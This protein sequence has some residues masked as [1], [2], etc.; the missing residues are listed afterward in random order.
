MRSELNALKKAVQDGEGFYEGVQREY[1]QIGAEYTERSSV[2]P[3]TGN[4]SNDVSIV[5]PDDYDAYEN[6]AHTIEIENLSLVDK[7]IE[8]IK[9][10]LDKTQGK[11]KAAAKELGISERTLYRKIKQYNLE[12]CAY[13]DSCQLY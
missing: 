4:R 6:D 13:F 11:R 9:K 2:T 10:A 8:L 1:P 5:N 3:Y 7:E 12:W